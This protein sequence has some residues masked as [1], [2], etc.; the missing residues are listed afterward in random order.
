[1][2]RRM[3]TILYRLGSLI[4]VL[5]ILG[6][7]A[8]NAQTIS[9]RQQVRANFDLEF[10]EELP[11]LVRE[12]AIAQRFVSGEL[13]A[14]LIERLKRSR[15]STAALR[16]SITFGAALIIFGLIAYALGLAARSASRKPE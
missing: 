10:K 16:Q 7:V 14:V 5:A 3:G 2:T 9:Q 6:A 12:D 4:A 13:P 1:M 15:A 8:W 11:P